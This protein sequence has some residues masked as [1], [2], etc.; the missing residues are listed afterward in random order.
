MLPKLVRDKIPELINTEGRSYRAYIATPEKYRFYLQLKMAEEVGEL[1]ETPTLNE[2]ADVYEVF[3]TMLDVFNL[4]LDDVIDTAD[5]KREIK[6]A[7][8]QGVILDE[9]VKIKE[10][11]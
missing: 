7:F 5:K 9:I 2:A 4:K 8:H 11:K 6:G 10:I 3:L 1:Y